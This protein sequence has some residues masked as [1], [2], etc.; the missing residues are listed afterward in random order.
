MR[1]LHVVEGIDSKRG[2][3]PVAMLSIRALEEKLNIDSHII[4]I[5]N[6]GDGQ[7]YPDS[8]HIFAASFPKRFYKSAKAIGWLKENIRYFDVLVIHG[9]WNFLCI[10]SAIIALK[11]GKKYIIWPHGSLDPFD[12]QKKKVLKILIGN[13]LANRILTNAYKLCFTAEQESVVVETY[14]ATVSKA[15]LPLPV[16]SVQ[17]TRP[18]G[19]SFRHKHGIEPDAFVFLFLGRLSYKKG[20]ETIIRATHTLHTTFTNVRIVIA[21]HD[22]SDFARELKALVDSLGLSD[23]IY[24]C[25]ELREADKA[26][27]L[28]DCDCFVLPSL[29]E[30]F[31]IA[32]IEALQ[33][34]LPVII[35]DNV[36]IASEIARL[37]GGWVCQANVE[38]LLATMQ[39]I[40]VNKPEYALRRAAAKT[41]G[42]HFLPNNLLSGYKAFY[43]AL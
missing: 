36:Y 19:Q 35:S 25:G 41:A 42:D 16:D 30:N 1:I 23:V 18:M 5:L 21:G 40:L 38:S 17:F 6:E 32:V 26:A 37:N 15:V 31:G 34:S 39:H 11:Q 3:L 22:Q 10:Q 9:F 24:F 4:S 20:I 29:N 14:G 7:E 12:L 43:D 2:G 13:S 28:Y 33:H 8:Y 27:A